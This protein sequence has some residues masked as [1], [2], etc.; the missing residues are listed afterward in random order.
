MAQATWSARVRHATVAVPIGRG[1]APQNTC[2]T[3]QNHG[4]NSYEDD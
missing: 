1:G 2:K 4:G 3:H